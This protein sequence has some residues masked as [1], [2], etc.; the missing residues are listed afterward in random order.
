MEGGGNRE[1]L[2]DC[3]KR[4]AT[5]QVLVQSAVRGCNLSLKLAAAGFEITRATGKNDG[6]R[7][8]DDGQGNGRTLNGLGNHRGR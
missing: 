4:S 1:E 2:D 6:T 8:I 3:L 7:A 5:G